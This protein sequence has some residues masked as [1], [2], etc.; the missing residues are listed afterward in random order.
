MYYNILYYNNV[1]Y[2]IKTGKFKEKRLNIFFESLSEASQSSK[3]EQ[4]GLKT[5]NLALKV[6]KRLLGQI[7]N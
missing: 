6:Q 2:Y 7:S 3:F 5:Y 4:N 1:Y